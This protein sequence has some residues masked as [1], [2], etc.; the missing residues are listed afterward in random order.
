[1]PDFKELSPKKIN[2]LGIY[3][4]IRP[5]EVDDHLIPE[6]A[7]TEA[8]NFSFDRKGAATV[9]PGFS[10][11]GGTVLASRPAVGLHNAQSGTAIAVF[12]NG[13]TSTIYSYDGSNWGMSLDGGTASVR[14]RFVDFASYTIAINFIQNTYGSMRFWNAGSSRHWHFTGSPINP[15]QMWGRTPQLGEVYK[16]R[17]YLGGDT[18]VEGASSRLYFSSVISSTGSITWQPTTDYVDI[19]PG[20]GEGMTGLK[21][22]SLELLVFKP[23]Y[24]YRFRTSSTDPDPLIKVGTRSHESIV[25]GKK[26]LYFWH[27]AAYSYSGGYPVEIS[28]P[29]SDIVSAIPFSQTSNIIG[30]NDQDHIYWSIGNVTITE[31]NTPSQVW[32]NVVVCYT[33]SSEIWTVYSLPFDVRRATTFNSGSSITRIIATDNGSVATQGSGTTD[34]GEPI[35]FQMRT[36]WEDWGSIISKKQIQQIVAVCEKAQNLEILYQVDE[37]TQ[38]NSI[39]QLKSMV[40]FYDNRTIVFH[41]IRFMVNGV[42]RFDAPI[43][44]SIEIVRGIDYGIV[45]EPNA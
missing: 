2:N 5:Q 39:A 6:G 34:L 4:V 18:S 31:A 26:A 21:R 20:D 43:M 13:S 28:R 15:Q 36:K 29:I 23:N 7:V 3:G 1:M 14:I 37:D 9:R 30:W 41:R 40:N 16:N 42:S 8:I 35:R 22:Y 38:W 45:K 17:V 19:N 27:N 25:E 44:R 33:E 24:I 12:S 11:L 32:K 10:A